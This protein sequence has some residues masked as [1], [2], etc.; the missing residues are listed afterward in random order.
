VIQAQGQAFCQLISNAEFRRCAGIRM[1]LELKN[2][3]TNRRRLGVGGVDRLAVGAFAVM[4]N[5]RT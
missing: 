5:S 2:V 3:S 4:V 1:I